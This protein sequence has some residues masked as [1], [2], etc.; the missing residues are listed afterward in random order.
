MKSLTYLLPY[1]RRY[2]SRLLLGLL[3]VLGMAVIGLLSPLVVGRAVD[4]FQE[5]VSLGTLLGYGGLILGIAMVQ[6]FFSFGQRRILVAMSRYVEYDLRNDYFRHLERLPQSFYQESFTGDLMARATNDLEAVRMVCGP[7]VMYSA[8]TLFAGIGAAVLMASIHRDLT[9]VVLCI[10]PFVAVASREVGTRIYHHFKRVQEQFSN[11]S[12][13]VQESFA[14]A[15][16]VRAYSQ[17]GAEVE[18]FRTLN[19]EYVSFNKGLIR[20]SAASRPLLQFLL[21]LGTLAVLV[22]GGLLTYL[23]EMTVGDLVMFN[24]FLGKLSWPMISLG[25]VINLVQRG[26]AS[27]GRIREVLELEPAIADPSSPVLVDGLRGDVAF[28]DLNFAYPSNEGLNVLE[29]IDLAI[30]AGTT[31]AVVGNT[32]SGKSTLLSL[33]PRMIDPPPNTVFV[34][35]IDIRR[36]PLDTLRGHIGLVPQETFLFSATVRENIVL[37]RPEAAEDEILEAARTAGLSSD[38][39]LLPDGL[40]TIVGERGITLSGGQKQRVALARALLRKPALLLLDDSLSAVDTQTEERIL[41]NL[42]QAFKGRTV[43]LVSH[44]ISTVKD[45]DLILVLQDGRIAEQ[46]VH[47]DL[48]AQDGLYSELYQRQQLEEQLAAV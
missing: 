11:L 39:E 41:I 14:G 46:G 34:D 19:R 21:G 12:T 25:W 27:L 43:F 22:Y 30:S 47:W 40:G 18:R 4:S 1:L 16:V 44:R 28:R 17:E 33:L 31:V 20:W 29:G 15:R 42:R 8:N 26:G 2:R 23:G 6:G 37:G 38:L 24:L 32:G 35:G 13:R 48:V 9:L 7:A 36:L 45:A 10:L 5:G 3:C